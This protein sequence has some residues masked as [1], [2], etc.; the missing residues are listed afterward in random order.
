MSNFATNILPI[1][2]SQSQVFEWTDRQTDTTVFSEYQTRN[3]LKTSRATLLPGQRRTVT[4]DASEYADGGVLSQEGHAV[5]YIFRKLSSTER[6]YSK[7]EQKALAIVFSVTRLKQFFLGRKFTFKQIANPC[8][9]SLS[10]TKRY[11]RQ[12]QLE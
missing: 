1:K 11:R 6:N 3:L 7:I 4:N 9:T 10:P 5:I 8:S 12:H 2:N